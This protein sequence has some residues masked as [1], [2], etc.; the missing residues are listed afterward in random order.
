M[1]AL[2]ISDDRSWLSQSESAML[3]GSGTTGR[4]LCRYLPCFY[5]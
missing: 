5:L 1:P 3:L 4:A 2:L